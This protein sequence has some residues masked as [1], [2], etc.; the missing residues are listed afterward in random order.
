MRR[1]ISLI[2]LAVALTAP[3]AAA[4][5]ATPIGDVPSAEECRVGPRP[6]AALA[7]TPQP[8]ID[9]ALRAAIDATPLAAADLPS[10]EPA[11]AA[12]VAGIRATLRELLA[13]I[14]AGDRE[15]LLS[16]FS[17]DFPST[18]L[19]TLGIYDVYVFGG[20]TMTPV[21]EDGR[22]PVP[23]VRE[24]RLLDG[25]GVGAI[26]GDA[27][28]ATIGPPALFI[29]FVEAD[30]RWL[31]DEVVGVALGEPAT[32]VVGTA[33]ATPA[34]IDG[35]AFMGVIVPESQ[36]D[37]FYFAFFGEHA[38]GYWTPAEADTRALEAEIVPF[39]RSLPDGARGGVAPDLWERL[40]GYG[41]QYVGIVED[42]RR[43]IFASFFCDDL[44]IDWMTEPVAV[45]DGG[46]C[47][48][49]VRYD[50]EGGTFSDLAVNGEA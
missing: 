27:E 31:I 6:A 30:G 38:E 34:A 16:L 50:V 32:P 37:G 15:R 29:L 2:A 28:A 9:D 14:H 8:T 12:T 40:P 39:L 10:G 1:L 35:D 49:Q 5:E 18:G 42:E 46:D 24:V 3:D 41:R 19:Y 25:G 47:Y 20:D 13:C 4:Q 36:A 48:V 43:L 26:V 21:P 33:E 23:P 22:M 45:E 7:G 11:D 44:G 17:D